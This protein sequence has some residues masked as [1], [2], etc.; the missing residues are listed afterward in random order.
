ML[1]RGD[2]RTLSIL[3]WNAGIAT[4]RS[5]GT[6]GEVD[7]RGE[8]VFL[9]IDLN[10]PFLCEKG[11]KVIM[12]S[13]LVSNLANPILPTIEAWICLCGLFSWRIGRD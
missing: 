6:L 12:A 13:H 3:F 9:H 4:T 8:K 2:W 5:V 10:M 7:L 1:W 11:A